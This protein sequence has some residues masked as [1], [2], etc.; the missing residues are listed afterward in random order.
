[1]SKFFVGGLPPSR[2]LCSWPGSGHRCCSPPTTAAAGAQTTFQH[3][4]CYNAGRPE[5]FRFRQAWS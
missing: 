1:M 4:L 2:L 3:Y 5:V